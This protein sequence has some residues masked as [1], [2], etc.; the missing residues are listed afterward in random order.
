MVNG[1][2]PQKKHIAIAQSVNVNK[3]ATASNLNQRYFLRRI[4]NKDESN[5]GKLD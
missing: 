3:Q 2:F 1:Q 4:T 5:G